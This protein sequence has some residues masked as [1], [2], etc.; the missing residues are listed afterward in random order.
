[1]TDDLTEKMAAIARAVAQGQYRY[2]VHGARQRIARSI[3]G[4]EVEEAI[5]DGEIIEDYPYHHYGPASLVFGKTAE[6]KVLHV[7]CGV[8][9]LVVI[10]TVYAPDPREWELDLRTRRIT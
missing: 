5:S 10:I 8:R 7:L 9:P 6:G 1:M 2:T 3:R 4:H